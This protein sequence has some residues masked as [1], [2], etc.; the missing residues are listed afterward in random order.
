M[1]TAQHGRGRTFTAA[2]AEA[3]DGEELEEAPAMPA[4]VKEAQAELKKRRPANPER[5]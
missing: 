4:L 1:E 3:G 5:R 2:A